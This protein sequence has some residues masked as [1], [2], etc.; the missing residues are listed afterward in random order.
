MS[1]LETESNSIK[2][3]SYAW[4][5]LAVAYI[6]SVAAPVAQ[7]KVPPIMPVLMEAFG[8][9]L[10]SA[11]MLMSVFAITGFILALP[12]G[13][14]LQKLGLKITGLIA[15][16]SIVIGSLL[17]VIAGSSGLLLFSRVIEGIGMGLIAVVAPAS[18]AMW[19]PPEKRGTPMGIWATWV[20]LG[21]V[22]MFLLAPTLTSAYGWQ[23][24][25]WF[26]AVFGIVAFILVWVFLKAP[27]LPAETTETVSSE[28]EPFN[29]G[30]ALANRDIWLLG[31]LFGLFNMA[32]IS[33][34]TYYPT[35][36]TEVRGYTMASASTT[37]STSMIVLLFSAPLAGI[38]SDK[39]G[40][41]KMFF[42]W[43]F[44]I[45]AIL[46]LLPFTIQG[47]AIP[48][49]LGFLGA[50]AGIIPAATFS[51]APEI[52]KK[53]ELSGLGMAVVTLGQNLG[54]FIGPLIFAAF[55]AS[56]GWAGAGYWMIPFL[57][58]GFLIG[59]LIKVR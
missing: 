34:S 33:I 52:M 47:S 50:F 13:I 14:I 28:E 2:V 57:L 40:S 12:A 43:P 39:L 3:P 24:A 6:T 4:V 38:L 1:H 46:F 27:P 51:A 26:S 35:F 49:W 32:T 48:L 8:L 22:L 9:N 41:R 23:A 58:L 7:F 42:T 11:G 56:S 16:G 30:K 44:L 31:A 54:M 55:Q 20:P 15:M 21:S 53:P 10:A 5:I 19:F 18:I 59:W 36:L 29:M 45:I 25:W 17:G 37:A